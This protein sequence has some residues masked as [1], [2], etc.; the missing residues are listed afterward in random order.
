MAA[1]W[2]EVVEHLKRVSVLQDSDPNFY[3]CNHF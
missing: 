3:C 2:R 1:S